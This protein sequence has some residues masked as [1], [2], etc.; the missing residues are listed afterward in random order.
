MH[1]NPMSIGC[2]I[3]LDPTSTSTSNKHNNRR[4]HL[5]HLAV[6]IDLFFPQLIDILRLSG[7]FYSVLLVHHDTPLGYWSA[8]LGLF[9]C[10]RENILIGVSFC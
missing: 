5:Q 2:R 4:D 10:S 8:I 1:I 7:D 6:I 3:L 9:D